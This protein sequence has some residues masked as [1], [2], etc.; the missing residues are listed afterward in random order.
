MPAGVKNLRGKFQGFG[1]GET[2]SSSLSPFFRGIRAGCESAI[3]AVV[4]GKAKRKAEG[5]AERFE[6]LWLDLLLRGPSTASFAD[7]ANDFAQ[8]DEVL[9]GRSATVSGD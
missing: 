1:Q 5:R 2:L 8:D 4:P 7:C 9:A 3:Q 6:L